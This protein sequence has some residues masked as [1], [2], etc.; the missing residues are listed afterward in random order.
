MITLIRKLIGLIF[1]LLLLRKIYKGYVAVNIVRECANEVS[2]DL[3]VAH[4]ALNDLSNKKPLIIFLLNKEVL[5]MTFNALCNTH[6]YKDVHDQILIVA[7]DHETKE[8][9]EHNWKHLKIMHYDVP[10]LHRPFNYGDGYYQLLYL[11]RANLARALLEKGFTFWMAQQDTF[12]RESLLDIPLSEGDIVFDRAGEESKNLIG[13]GHYFC[14]NTLKAKQFFDVLSTDLTNKYFPDNV[15]MTTLCYRGIAECNYIPF[16]KIANWK[17]LYDANSRKSNPSLIQF[18]GHSNLGGKLEFM[19]SLGF[20]FLNEDGKTCN[21]ESIEK[22]RNSISTFES[23]VSFNI[24]SFM[25]FAFYQ[26]IIELFYSNS[27]LEFVMN[28]V[29]FPN[30][31]YFMITM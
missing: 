15:Y 9:L 14:R 19:K 17:W 23:D 24:I 13:G 20:Y 21:L 27:L 10:C 12:W 16:E 8:V 31:M 29:I 5:N 1:I 11:F 18:D 2:V 26:K 6:Q 28:E 4:P 25:Q 7:L 30:A 3:I 22:A